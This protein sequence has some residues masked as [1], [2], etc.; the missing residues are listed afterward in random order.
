[1]LPGALV[2]GLMGIVAGRLFDKHGPRMLSIVGTGL[3]TLS[4]VAFVFFTDSTT[5][6][7]ITLIYTVRMFSMSLVNMPINTWG[8][9]A[10][11]DR[12]INHGTSVSNTFRQ[13]AGSLG[14]AVIV[15]VSTA[16]TN[17][18]L[19]TMD[20]LHASIHGTN[21]A[22]LV[23]TIM[24]AV[25]LL[26]VVLLVRDKAGRHRQGGSGQPASRH[27]RVGHEDRRVHAARQR[28]GARRRAPVRGQAHQR[29]AAGRREDRR[30]HRLRLRRRRD[31]L[32]VQAPRRP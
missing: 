30:G 26:L 19:A 22:F 10:L 16:V 9:N 29:R 13:V 15:S 24:C 21:M 28:L 7:F 17:S 6:G 27:P 32:P 11:D 8:M 25:G 14:T 20:Q 2:M 3:L 23:S 18:S 1:M 5:I 12:L 4:S 31:A